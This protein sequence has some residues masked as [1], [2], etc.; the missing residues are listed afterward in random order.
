MVNVTYGAA[1]DTTPAELAAFYERVKHDC[2]VAERN[3][4]PDMLA[5][6]A[7]FVA[8]RVDGQLVGIARGVTDG[9]RGY[10]AECKLD[11]VYQ[12]PAS[13]TKIDGRIEHDAYGIAAEMAR[14][15]I[16]G[17]IAHG[18]GRIDVVAWGTEADFLEEL[19]FRRH[20]GLVG[21]T[22][23]P[24]AVRTASSAAAAAH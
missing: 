13:V 1:R 4:I 19:G 5:R 16:D 20:G 9:V 10:F 24:D 7:A 18:A 12:G 23:K 17:L 8:A 2:D 3:R 6:S 14:R 22:L 11:P 15:V 21:L